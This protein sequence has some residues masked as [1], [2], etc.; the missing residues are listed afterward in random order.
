MCLWGLQLVTDTTALLKD[1]I[2]FYYLSLSFVE[3]VMNTKSETSDLRWTIYPTTDPEVHT[4]TH[5]Y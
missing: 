3:V 5:T 1:T 2:C 4:H